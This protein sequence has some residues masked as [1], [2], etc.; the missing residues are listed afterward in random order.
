MQATASVLHTVKN[1]L[2]TQN[3]QH[4]PRQTETAVLSTAEHAG[5]QTDSTSSGTSISQMLQ[6]QA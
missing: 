1:K 6:Q 3:I 4:T 5:V 2:G